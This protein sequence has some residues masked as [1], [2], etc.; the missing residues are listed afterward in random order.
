[1]IETQDKTAPADTMP[2]PG[3]GSLAV[4]LG[5]RSY[6]IRVGRGLVAEAAQAIDRLQPGAAIAVI[7][8]QNVAAAG[9]LAALR[10]ALASGGLRHQALV[11]PAGEATK[12]LGPLSS[13]VDFLL[14]G[15]FERRDLVV[16]LGGGVI[17]DLVGFAAAITRRGIG[18]VQIP[19]TLLAQVDSSVG[20]KTAINAA[21]GKNLI[22]VFHQPRLV[23]CD[24][25]LLDTLTLREMRAGYAEVM[26]Y[27]LLG[28]AAFFDWLEA[29]AWQGVFAGGQE[30]ERAV[31]ASCRMK[32]GIVAR[33]ETE[34]GERAL[35][36]LGH[37]FG[38]ALEAAVGYDAGRLVH[39]EAIAIGMRLAFD[40]SVEQGLC[41]PADSERVRRHLEAVGLPTRIAQIPGDIGSADTLLDAIRQDKKVSRGALTFILARG[42]GQAFIAKDV[43]PG[44][45]HAY[46]N[47]EITAA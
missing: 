19:T 17:G 18:F 25:A 3:R 32:A 35:L 13:V 30:R 6:T 23:L 9:H 29:G 28:D 42:I 2:A 12:A 15:R 16:A 45:V 39:G 21:Q 7:T 47:R 1:M 22:G 8:D 11:L 27:G 46:I 34:T 10:S 5:A 26:K 20:G 31:L 41:P 24:T 4:D 37:T 36:N 44:R 38:H 14:D 40:F 43:D 33:D